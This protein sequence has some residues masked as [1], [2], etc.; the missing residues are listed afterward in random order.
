M[1]KRRFLGPELNSRQIRVLYCISREYIATGKPVSS[2]QVLE[3]SNLKYSSATVRN[4]MRKLE[5]LGYINQP[6][7]SAGRVLTDKGLRFYLDSI[8]NIS[9]DLQESNVAIALQQVSFIGD[10]ERLLQGMTRILAHS[11]SSFVVIEK[12]KLRS[13]LVRAIS[14]SRIAD[15]YLNV[16]VITDLGVGLNTTVF[17]GDGDFD[18]DN[19]QYQL[20]MAVVGKTIEEIRNGIKS[21]QI[22]EDQWYDRR[23]QDILRF[24]QS[25][26]EKEQEEKYFSYGL[27]FVISSEYLDSNDITN[28]IGS[29]ENPA[30][31]EEL[32][33]SLGESD[34]SKVFIGEE[35]GREEL[36]N[37]VI[38]S[39][40][41]TRGEEKLGTVYII[42]P[43]LTYYEKLYGYLEFATNRLSEVF[44]K[45]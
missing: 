6:H 13:L 16:S 25:I 2:K 29:V 37:Y 33:N 14:L 17:V 39:S 35:I 12:P 38:F 42:A 44:S 40:P 22:R 21:V 9:E 45:R 26:F 4:D 18:I 31:L 19:F 1:A 36:K 23:V 20:N 3:H 27:E 8:K 11:T 32:L 15:G 28:L 43:K 10:I 34:V 41:Y 24:L 30:N 5:F 7:T